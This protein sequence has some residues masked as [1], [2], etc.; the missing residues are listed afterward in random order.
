MPSSNSF[1][2]INL[3]IIGLCVI[4]TLNLITGCSTFRDRRFDYS[5]QA[6]SLNESLKLPDKPIFK[7]SSI[8]ADL[9]MPSGQ[10]HYK[11]ITYGALEKAMRPPHYDQNMNVNSIRAK[12]RKQVQSRLVFNQANEALLKTDIKASMAWQLMIDGIQNSQA[13]KLISKNVKQ[14]LA[15]V[16]ST[17]NAQRYNVYVFKTQN[18]THIAVF[19]AQD[20]LAQ[21]RQERQLLKKLNQFLANQS[22]DITDKLKA[23]G[24][25]TEQS[26]THQLAKM[27]VKQNRDKVMLAFDKSKAKVWSALLQAIELMRWQ[28]D[29]VDK[30]KGFVFVA[31]DASTSGYQYTIYVHPYKETGGMFSDWSNW[32]NMFRQK[33]DQVRI[34]IFNDKGKTFSINQTKVLLRKLEQHMQIV[35]NKDN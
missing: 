6:V 21:G 14:R 35:F 4:L 25:Q 8:N 16:K 27:I 7:Q 18:W 9:T 17:I 3:I 30:E 5:R 20:E 15:K 2:S 23:E 32:N 28:I 26:D 29:S 31:K 22:V 11:P 1:Q 10:D 33:V 13:F 34:S 24:D 19:N 12:E